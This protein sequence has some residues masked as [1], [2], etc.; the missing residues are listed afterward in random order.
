M[1]K[2][3]V[4]IQKSWKT[5]ESFMD[6]PYIFWNISQKYVHAFNLKRALKASKH[7]TKNVPS[8]KPKISFLSFARKF[9]SLVRQ[10]CSTLKDLAHF[11]TG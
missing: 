2:V 1:R 9:Y 6:D 10:F 7:L 3:A 8:S 5:G 4:G 11:I